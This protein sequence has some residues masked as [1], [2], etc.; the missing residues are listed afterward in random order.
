M[1]HPDPDQLLLYA[2]GADVAAGVAEH[3]ASCG[4]C[5]DSLAELG[6]FET[7]LAASAS[8]PADERAALR[9]T[10]ARLLETHS[11]R[12]AFRRVWGVVAVAIAAAV[13]ATLALWPSPRGLCELGVRRYEPTNVVRAERMERFAI[14]VDLAAPR[15]L[16][17]WQLDAKSCQR[18]MPHAD[19]LLRW[20]GA[21]M[22]LQP[23]KHRLPAAEVLDFE[24]AA[25]RPPEGLVVVAQAAEWTEAQLVAIEQSINGTPRS[26]LAAAL[27][28]QW[29]EARLVG[30]PAK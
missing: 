3:I 27:Q 7:Q 15:W 17:V 14:D 29:P 26:E 22:P 24:F 25:A 1:T 8:L 23:G 21:E 4:E 28:R 10:T 6:R 18:L 20:L 2:E 12:P 16:A 5:R 9:S 30:F 19:P 13:L 11:G